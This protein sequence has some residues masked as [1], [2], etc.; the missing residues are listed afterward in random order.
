M[1]KYLLFEREEC[2][3]KDGMHTAVADSCTP[4]N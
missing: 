3:A 4:Y 2:L 1:N